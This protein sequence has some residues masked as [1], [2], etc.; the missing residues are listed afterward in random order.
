[1]V[2]SGKSDVIIKYSCYVLGWD[3]YL[4]W[5]SKEVMVEYF[6]RM[7]DLK[8]CQLLIHK[9]LKCTAILFILMVNNKKL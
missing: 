9:T 3:F 1:M 4:Y 8:F 7:H 5:R 2:S 6:K